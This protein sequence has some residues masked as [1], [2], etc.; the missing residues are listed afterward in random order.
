MHHIMIVDDEHTVVDGLAYRIPW[1]EAGI[2]TVH[3]AYSGYEALA[4]ASKE[5]VDIVLTDIRMPGMDGLDLIRHIRFLKPRAKIILLSGHAEFEYAQS[6]IQLGADH[7]MIKPVRDEELLETLIR[8]SQELSQEWEEIASHR[9][10][11]ASLQEHTPAIRAA[12][13][14]DL[15]HGRK[16]SGNALQEKLKDLGLPFHSG[17]EVCVMLIR[18]EE[19]F[20]T[21]DRQSL[22][23]MEYAIGNIAEEIMRDTCQLWLGKESHDYLVLLVKGHSSNKPADHTGTGSKPNLELMAGTLQ[24]NVKKYLHGDVSIALSSWG[25]FPHHLPECYQ[26][27]LLEMRRNV[28]SVGGLLI[29][30]HPEYPKPEQETKG[31][32]SL[33]EPPTLLNLLEAGRW[34]A[35]MERLDDIFTELEA[36]W[37][38]S[39]EHWLEVGSTLLSTYL[40][41]AHKNG[42]RLHELS[43]DTFNPLLEQDKI[44]SIKQLRQASVEQ[45]Q[46]LRQDMEQETRSA[47]SSLVAQIQLYVEQHL[48]EDVSLQA[49]ADQVFLNPGYLSKIFKL[50]TGE[51][52]SDYLYRLRMDRAVVMLQQ[53][54]MKIYQISEKLGYQNTPYFIKV[55]KKYFGVTPQEYR[56]RQ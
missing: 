22:S 42:K 53:T 28:S 14:E 47:R 23:L 34:D 33:Y 25:L 43:G 20:H 37:Q 38:H 27:V 16:F 24:E 11:L 13:L 21:Y 32:Q 7:Y 18:L 48:S 41:L 4:I 55:F 30:T 17:G 46:R 10:A 35:A 5:S 15:L 50:E 49:I 2:G 56:D 8:L 26:K 36:H 6:A 39:Q 45:L 51:N 52:I 3:K 31:M 54:P 12:L 40:N 19:P 9:R 1:E 44:R 29:A